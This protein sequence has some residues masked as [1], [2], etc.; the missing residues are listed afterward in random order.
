VHIPN[1][2]GKNRAI[3]RDESARRISDSS[4]VPVYSVW[5]SYM[6]QGV[7]GGK[8]VSGYTQALAI[9]SHYLFL[10]IKTHETMLR[11]MSINIIQ[12]QEMERKRLSCELHDEFGQAL[13]AIGI[14]LGVIEK[15][16]SAAQ[17]KRLPIPRQSA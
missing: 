3:S 11:Q 5:D 2:S 13:T 14:N 7:L 1:S 10:E 4:P 16:L 8:L 6:G 12:A 17:T 9:Q 15:K